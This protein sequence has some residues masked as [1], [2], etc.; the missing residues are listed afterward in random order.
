MDY[1]NDKVKM[2]TLEDMKSLWDDSKHIG[3]F[4]KKLED[5]PYEVTEEILVDFDSFMVE[6]G[7]DIRE[8]FLRGIRQ[9][10]EQNVLK[11]KGDDVG[12]DECLNI[13]EA[14]DVIAEAIK[15]DE[16]E[17]GSKVEAVLK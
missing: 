15:E 14:R 5:A 2:A 4:Y 6:K 10:S 8:A 11:F 1:K 16:L 12:I 3:E 17:Q 7:I 13:K 9:V